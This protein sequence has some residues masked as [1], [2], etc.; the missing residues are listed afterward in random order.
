MSNGTTL[1]R[2][3]AFLYRGGLCL[4]TGTAPWQ[5]AARLMAEDTVTPRLRLGLITDLHYADK[6][7]SGSRHYRQTIDKLT[8]AAGRFA[9]DKPQFVVELGDLIDAA[10]SVA[11][12]QRY[13]KRIQREFSQLACPRHC[14]LG[15]H[16]VD[17]LTKREFLDGVSQ[18]KSFY[19]F[20]AAGYHFIVLD[21]CFRSDGR[22]YQRRNFDWTDPNIPPHEVEWLQADLAATGHKTIV[23]AHQRLDPAGNHSVK[24]AAQVRRVLEA[25]G[26][27]LAVFQGHSHENHHA[28]I[29]GIHY[30]TL[31]G[32]VEGSGQK[33]NG[34][35]TVD[36]HA[37]DV[38][39]LTGYRRQQN[40][41]WAA[42]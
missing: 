19:A 21:A 39:R 14:V 28:L 22:P 2:R 31:V 7:P 29:N 20:D 1:L 26:K 5:R 27:V 30:C 41:R 36:L 9:V 13:L 6:A 34:Y 24:N 38:I 3:R 11:V 35:A 15:N 17:T 10:D 8:E 16:C 40:Y 32:M 25:S 18:P 33:N 37:G 4:L 12:E 23:F 42:D